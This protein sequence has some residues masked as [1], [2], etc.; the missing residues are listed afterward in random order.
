MNTPGLVIIS[1]SGPAA[2][3][4]LLRCAIQDDDPVIFL[5]PRSLYNTKGEVRNG[6]DGL[7]PIGT[8]RMAS[9]SRAKL[10]SDG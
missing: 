9:D 3:Y 4:G 2:A 1:P 8:A 6:E 5:E 7:W 10:T